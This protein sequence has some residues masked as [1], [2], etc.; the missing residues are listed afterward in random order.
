MDRSDEGP[1]RAVMMRRFG[2][3]GSGILEERM[4]RR[5]E[6]EDEEGRDVVEAVDEELR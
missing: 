4:S 5:L 3:W 1:E 6:L 2:F